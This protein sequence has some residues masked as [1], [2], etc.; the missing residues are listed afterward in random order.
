MT[1]NYSDEYTDK[2]VLLW[3]NIYFTQLHSLTQTLKISKLK[4]RHTNY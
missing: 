3:R 1:C 2:E 4:K